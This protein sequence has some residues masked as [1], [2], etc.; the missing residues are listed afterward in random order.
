MTDYVS[1]AGTVI[2]NLN[3][4]VPHVHPQTLRNLAN[5]QKQQELREPHILE[6]TWMKEGEKPFQLINEECAKAQL[7]HYASY[8]H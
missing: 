1:Q 4:H 2:S 5:M 6:K 7:H 8:Q 3:L